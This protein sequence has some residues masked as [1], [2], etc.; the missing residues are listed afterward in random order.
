MDWVGVFRLASSAVLA[1]V[2]F[3]MVLLL[4]AY[5]QTVIPLRREIESAE[6]LAPPIKWTYT[7]HCAVLAY[8]LASGLSRV[9]LALSDAPATV[10]TFLIPVVAVVLAIAASKFHKYYVQIL[11]TGYYRQEGLR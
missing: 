2:A 4:I 1:G 11:R 9:Q 6:V 8:V 5:R 10:G 7:Y 3:E